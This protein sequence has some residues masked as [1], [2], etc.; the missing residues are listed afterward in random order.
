[1]LFLTSGITYSQTLDK[2]LMK[3]LSTS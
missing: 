3:S 2:Q 1:M